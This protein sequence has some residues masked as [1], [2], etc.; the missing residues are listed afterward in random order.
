MALT[1][2]NKVAL[3]MGN[4]WGVGFQIAFDSSYA[5]GG[6]SLL[7]ADIGLSTILFTNFA[8]RSGFSFEYDYTNQVLK[9]FVQG[10]AH[11]TAGAVTMD[12][13]AVTAGPGVSS[14]ISISREASAGAATARWGPQKE[15]A[16]SDDL[17]TLTSVRGFAIGY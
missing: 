15:V 9:V 17:S 7:P 11:A 14:G 10:A 16:A 4:A 1:I 8:P 13:Y 12:D 3:S 6:E 5:S 2:S